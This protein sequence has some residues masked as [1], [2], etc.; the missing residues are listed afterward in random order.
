MKELSMEEME[1]IKEGDWENVACGLAGVA[2]CWL[3]STVNVGV[4]IACGVYHAI[5]CDYV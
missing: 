2:S 5:A 4:G 1:G 3:W